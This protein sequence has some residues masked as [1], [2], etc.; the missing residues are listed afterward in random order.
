MNY[1]YAFGAGEADGAGTQ[2]ELLG[3][4]GASLAEM[5]RL[6]LPVPPGFTISTECCRRYLA[7]DHTLPDKAT[8]YPFDG[9]NPRTPSVVAGF[10]SGDVDPTP[11]ILSNPG[12]ELA[13]YQ[14]E[15]APN[16]VLLVTKDTAGDTLRFDSVSR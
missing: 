14:L 8:A 9:T 12:I 13:F 15:P 5:T 4:K 6:G 1:I 7:A 11:G 10:V 2:K 3:G 16:T